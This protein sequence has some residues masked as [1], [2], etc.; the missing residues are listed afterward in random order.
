M[1]AESKVQEV[2]RQVGIWK[3]EAVDHL[4]SIFVTE[5]KDRHRWFCVYMFVKVGETYCLKLEGKQV[6]ARGW[7]KILDRVGMYL[8]ASCLKARWNGIKR[9]KYLWK[10]VMLPLLRTARRER[11]E[12]KIDNML[13]KRWLVSFNWKASEEYGRGR[14][15]LGWDW[16]S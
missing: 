9:W 1:G 13:L 7:L 5:W 10:K 12:A 11:T 8:G 4:F 15:L 3:M 2:N 6:I 14:I 16:G